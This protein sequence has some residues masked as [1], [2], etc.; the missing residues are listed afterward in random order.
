MLGKKILFYLHS[1]KLI[2][3]SVKLKLNQ[4]S[5]NIVTLFL[6]LRSCKVVKVLN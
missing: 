1:T 2:A 3:S 6:E 4:N 5:K